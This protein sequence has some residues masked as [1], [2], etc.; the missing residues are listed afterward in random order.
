MKNGYPLHMAVLSS[1]FDITLKMLDIPSLNPN[2]FNSV[3]ANIVHL[4]FVKYDKDPEIARKVLEKCIELDI[5][6]NL[7]DKMMAA[8]IHLALGKK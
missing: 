2:V 5:Q 1:K 6:L 3:G 7:I 8:P 4:L